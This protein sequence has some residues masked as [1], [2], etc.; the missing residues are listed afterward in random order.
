MATSKKTHKNHL[1]ADGENLVIETAAGDVSIPR[2]KP[3]AGLIRKNRHLSEVD[4][5][6]TMLEHFA[7]DKAL[8][9]TDELGPEDL[10][11][12]FKQWQELSGANLGE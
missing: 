4:L 9:V 6:F 1:P 12:F 2:F 7:D 5:M 10:A 8:A 3:K 11:D